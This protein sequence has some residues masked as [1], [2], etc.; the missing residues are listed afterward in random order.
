MAGDRKKPD[1]ATSTEAVA[2]E[3]A[4]AQGS[5]APGA[6]PAQARRPR[7]RPSSEAVLRAARDAWRRVIGALATLVTVAAVV[8]AVILALHI[9]FVVFNANA[10]NGMVRFI[11]NMA[12]DLVFGFKDLFLPRN[13]KVEI[14]VN[15]AVAAVVYLIAGGVVSRIIRRLG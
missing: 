11:G 4:K 8:A 5:A 1:P 3:D 15:Y 7:R 2:T 9:V 10:Q 13:P 6:A 14:F 12:D